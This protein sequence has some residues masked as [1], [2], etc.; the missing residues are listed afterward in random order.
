LEN[1]FIGLQIDEKMV[2]YRNG[3][4]EKNS[5]DLQKL[6]VRNDV[7]RGKTVSNRILYGMENTVLK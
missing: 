7:I 6:K 2:K 3:A 1:L 4:L 5:K